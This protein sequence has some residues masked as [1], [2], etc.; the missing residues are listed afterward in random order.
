MSKASK[1]SDILFSPLIV[2]LIVYFTVRYLFPE[3][4]VSNLE[5]EIKKGRFLSDESLC[6][7]LYEEFEN[8]H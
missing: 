6:K 2:G 4:Q 7:D 1:F 3:K 5:S 8:R